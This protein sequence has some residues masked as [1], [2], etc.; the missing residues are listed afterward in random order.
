MQDKLHRVVI[1]G[2]G[3]IT[4]LGA[5]AQETWDGL[6]AGKSGAGVTTLFDH[7]HLETHIAAEVK[8]FDPSR[9][10]GPKEARR[11]DRNAQFAI[12]AA[13]EALED[14]KITVTDDNT[15]E[16]GVVLG[17]GVGGIGTII[18]EHTVLMQKG[19][20]RVSPFSVPMMLPDT[21]T[22][23]VAIQFGIR[24]PNM[25][26]VSACASSNNALGESFEMIRAGRLPMILSGG[27]EAAINEF[28]VAAFANMG[29][30]SARNNEPTKAS[31]PFDKNRDGFVSGEGAAVLVLESLESAQARGAKIYAE[32][33]GYGTSADAHHITAPDPNGAQYAMRMA[34]R[35]AGV[36]PKQVDY[37]NAHGTSTPLN[38]SSETK[39]IKMV[40]G[41]DAYGL[42]ISSTKSMTGH[43][44][45]A[46]GAVEA[47]ACV[48]AINTG[49]IP[50]TINYETPDPECD[51][52]YTPNTAAHKDVR[53]AMSN[54][55]GF[56]GHN[57]VIV[58]RR[59]E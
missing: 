43:L 9:H 37:L 34:L 35:Q 21:A 2:L 20:R 40:F 27:C 29:A 45:G 7:S 56:G 42:S 14:A 6:A 15:H 46:A 59:F 28:A 8:G 10:F 44:L 33:I 54:S 24:G 25:C 30:T 4:P 50:P 17:S 36:A 22:G 55:F 1:T 5:N 18:S 13:K 49:L 16:I 19:P 58:L 51:L 47:L 23:Q 38:D 53:I 48:K 52:N 32:M 11:L 57:A 3:A 26:V 39:A 12:V 31:R 41:E